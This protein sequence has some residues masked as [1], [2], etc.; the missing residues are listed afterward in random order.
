MSFRICSRQ[1]Y[2]ANGAIDV[3]PGTHRRVYKFWQYAMEGAYKKTTR[4]PL[5]QGDVLIRTSNLWHRGMPNLTS[6]ARPMLAFT[7]GEKRTDLPDPFAFNDGKISFHENWFRPNLAGRIK[8][9]A[10]VKVPI[11]YSALRFARS[12]V[13]DSKGYD[14]A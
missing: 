8:E 10:F 4:L 2:V 7:F 11:A 14:H 9:Q 5:E 3:L 12:L 6:T 1:R 13:A